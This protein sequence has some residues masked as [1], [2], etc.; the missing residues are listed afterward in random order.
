[1][2]SFF[3][4]VLQFVYR[5][6]AFVVKNLKKNIYS[7]N[8]KNFHQSNDIHKH[9]LT[10]DLKTH[11]KPFIF[12]VPVF[13]PTT[14]FFRVIN[15]DWWS[16]VCFEALK[17]YCSLC[18]WSE[19]KRKLSVVF[20]IVS[21]NEYEST[22]FYRKNLYRH[23]FLPTEPFATKLIHLTNDNNFRHFHWHSLS[24]H[25][26][27]FCDSHTQRRLLQQCIHSHKH[28]VA[29]VLKNYKRQLISSEMVFYQLLCST[30]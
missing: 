14:M 6:I 22:K 30:V 28:H 24:H 21:Q 2:Q 16:L 13:L 12:T 18:F 4:R 25:H 9:H 7:P 1:M 10:D 8:I 5:T 11:C 3:I 19:E 17:T 20:I 15:L 23:L 26:I 29:D 27:Y